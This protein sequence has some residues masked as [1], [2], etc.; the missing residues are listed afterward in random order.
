MLQDKKNKQVHDYISWCLELIFPLILP[1][2]SKQGKMIFKRSKRAKMILPFSNYLDRV[3][4]PKT[5]T[6]LIF[7][8]HLL[9]SDLSVDS[10]FSF[11]FGSKSDF[12]SLQTN[13]FKEALSKTAD[14][15]QS[16]VSKSKP[17]FTLAPLCSIW[18]VS[19]HSSTI[20]CF[21]NDLGQCFWTKEGQCRRTVKRNRW[22]EIL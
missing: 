22:C 3:C 7:N 18:F 5:P 16:K 14:Q 4:C 13:T 6:S 21:N 15:E 1:C 10:R 19:Q 2:R 20:W 11:S 12:E 17:F 9:H 8:L